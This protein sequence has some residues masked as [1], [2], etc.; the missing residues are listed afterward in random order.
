M[1]HHT[2]WLTLFPGYPSLLHYAE[3]HHV[4]VP[5]FPL[6]K[7]TTVHHVF[8]ALLVLVILGLASMVARMKIANTEAAVVP[9]RAFGVVAFFELFLETLMGL[10]EQII[11]PTYRRYVPLIGTLGLFV[12]VSNLI[13]LVP[14]MRPSTDSLSTTFACGAVVFVYFN[15]HG[16]RTNGIK[17]ITHIMNPIGAW[18]GWFLFPLL[19]P[20]ELISVCVRPVT[21]A[22]RL[23]ANMIGDPAVLFAFAGILPLLGPLPFYA[24]G[25]LVCLIQTAVFCIL[26]CVYIALHTAEPEH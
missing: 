10:M 23:A 15:Y 17:H 16:L 14:G 4:P 13:G 21:L 8:S 25:L 5:S 3:A 1:D 11:G 26:S 9:P 2:S 19:F 7:L 24:L 18:W 6:W 22:I 12:L 20:V